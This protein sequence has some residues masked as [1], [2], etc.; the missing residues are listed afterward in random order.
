MYNL[1]KVNELKLEYEKENNCT[2]D[3]CLKCRAD[4]LWH[5]PITETELNRAKIDENILCPTAWDFKS[6]NKFGV[7]DTSA[8]CNSETMNKY[9]SFIDHVDQYFDEGNV[10]HPETYNGIHIDRMGLITINNIVK[11][12]FLSD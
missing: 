12:N 4:A 8:L 11:I 2:Y 10:F 9:S 3:L 7:S 5:T 6:I 1:K